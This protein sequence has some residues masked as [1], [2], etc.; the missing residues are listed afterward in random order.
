MRF[1]PAQSDPRQ[2]NDLVRTGNPRTRNKEQSRESYA[3]TGGGRRKRCRYRR[4]RLPGGGI[5]NALWARG[6]GRKYGAIRQN[7]AIQR[8]AA[9]PGVKGFASIFCPVDH[10][11]QE[12]E[13]V[14]FAKDP[15]L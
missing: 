7:R 10:N 1:R 8:S 2:P 15:P 14:S 12:V 5:T 9:L 13:G 6:W 11:L 3:T 4:G